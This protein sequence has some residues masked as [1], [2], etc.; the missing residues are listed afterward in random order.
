MLALLDM[1]CPKVGGVI[2]G[3]PGLH[4]CK[5]F[6]SEKFRAAWRPAELSASPVP[7]AIAVC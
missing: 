4:N 2:S 1:R 5:T 6:N 3:A 7:G